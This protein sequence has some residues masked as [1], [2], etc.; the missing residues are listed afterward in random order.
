[1]LFPPAMSNLHTAI[2]VAYDFSH[3]G[4][5]AL[6]R[7]VT[8]AARA[9]TSVLHVVCVVDPHDPIPSIPIYDGVDYLYAARVQE[10]LA[11]TVQEELEVA[12]P[13]HRVSFFVHARI[14][15]PADEILELAREIGADLILVGSHKLSGVERLL[16]GSV[17]EKLV[18]E[19]RCSVEV[20]RVK[21][22]ADVDLIPVV[23]LP[24]HPDHTYV[25]PHRYEYEDHRV[26]MRP[27]EWPLY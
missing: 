19:A 21:T 2:V 23:E 20:A 4:H 13:M 5:A 1:L 27:A 6:S 9:P 25:P 17:S 24:G 26:M 7:A 12:A 15:K 22:Y 18:R 14:G 3:T 16:L 8:L 10:A 11:M